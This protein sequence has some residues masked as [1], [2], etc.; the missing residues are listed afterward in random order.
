MVGLPDVAQYRRPA[1]RRS[2]EVTRGGQ[3]GLAPLRLVR[4]DDGGRHVLPYRHV[5]AD[6]AV[7]PPQLDRDQGPDHVAGEQVV[8]VRAVPHRPACQPDDDVAGPQVAG[9]VGGNAGDDGRVP[10]L[11]VDVLDPAGD[12]HP[13][14][15]AA[16]VAVLQDLPD[17][18]VDG[19][20]G[21]GE[22]DAHRA[23]VDAGV[24]AEH[25]PGRVDQRAAAVPRVDGGIGLDG[26]LQRA[27]ALGGYRAGQAGDDPDADRLRVVAQ[28]AAH[29]QAD[30]AEHRRVRPHL[31]RGR[32]RA[33]R[34]DDGQVGQRVRA[35][36]RGRSH[37][38]GSELYLQVPVAVVDDV[39]V[40]DDV[41][42][43]IDQEAGSG[44][45]AR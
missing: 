14:R 38:P 44:G 17:Y 45:H 35:D 25:Q 23:G 28:R 32:Q 33:L 18:P 12:G 20:A 40:G 37:Q 5:A 42:R 22:A 27:A 10:E 43:A 34:T 41:P 13:Q 30:L 1:G 31:Q 8:Q 29:G 26:P 9:Q 6:P 7:L 2:R 3:A 36:Q 4:V 15:A 19:L 21:N 39:V 24:H 11:A 16:D